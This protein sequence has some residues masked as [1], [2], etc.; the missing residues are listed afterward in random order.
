METND[1]RFKKFSRNAVFAMLFELLSAVLSFVV[2]YFFIHNLSIEYLGM[3][4]L[5]SNILTI[6]SLAEMGAGTAIVYSMYKPLAVNDVERIKSLMQL[7]RRLYL[8]IG[9]TISILGLC[10]I[11]FLNFLISGQP[12]IPYAEFILIYILTVIQTG[13]SYLFCYRY[14]IYS[15]NQQEYI[16][17]KY[18]MLFSVFSSLMQIVILISLKN[19]VAY[20]LIRIIIT[21]FQNIFLSIKAGKDYPYLKEIADKLDKKSLGEIK[22]NI[23][24]LLLYKMGITVA[25]TID[26]LLMSKYFGLIAVGLYS[27]YHLIFGYSDKFF[28]SVLGTITPSLGNLMVTGTNREENQVFS[29]LQLIYYWLSTYLAVGLIVLFNPLIECI[30]G[31]EYLF[32]QSMV[33]ALVIS[34]TLT[35]FQRPC[36][37]TRDATGLFW[38]GKLRPLVM[39]VLNI[40]LS[41]IAIEM[42]G[43]IGIVLGTILSK[44]LTYVWYDPYIVYK[45]AIKGSLVKYYLNYV[46]QWGL[47]VVLV[48]ICN[49]IYKYMDFG[50]FLN[51]ILGAFMV[52]IVV[53]GIFLIVNARN[54][55]MQYLINLVKKI[56]VKQRRPDMN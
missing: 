9:M 28:T 27:N 40:V 48:F 42:F 45:Y 41:L 35:N 30:F 52:T 24:A 47:L 1:S 18:S 22:K 14:S 44:V 3:G 37:L 13:S 56:L 34:I 46:F 39:S 8:T 50:G 20:L 2:R 19:Y 31:E 11:P 21:L 5:F 12:N 16:V 53:N 55:T 7:Y 4:G 33:T 36:S 26:T 29:A 43:I 32:D 54:K 38:R 15:A 49:T 6:L 51:I 10:L 17:K 25:T 23:F